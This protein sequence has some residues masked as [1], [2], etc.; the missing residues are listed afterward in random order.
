M[1]TSPCA[2]VL[3]S[4]ALAALPLSAGVADLPLVEV[5]AARPSGNAVAILVS[6]DGGW[7]YF[8]RRV[9]SELA[10]SGVSSVGLNSLKYLFHRKSPRTL[11]AD[12]ARIMDHCGK[13]RGRDRFLLVGYSLGADLLPTMING[14]PAE[15]R[16]R[17]ASL[18]LLA[19]ARSYDLEFHFSEW[20]WSSR[21]G[22]LPLLPEVEKLAGMRI[23]CVYGKE[24][25]EESLCPDLAPGTAR[26][27]ALE[28]GH[29][30][31]G[32]VGTIVKLV[33]E[34][35]PSRSGK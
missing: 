12:L 5:P 34:S 33:L 1:K 8:I 3:L 22:N 21:R 29:H 9:A 28:G 32:A 26:V 10:D 17:I 27:A 35:D 13:A 20:L 11:S 30:F 31:N 15:A 24:E 19:P 18:T 14:L 2:P 16:R 23:V 4:M 25:E 6:G 7:A